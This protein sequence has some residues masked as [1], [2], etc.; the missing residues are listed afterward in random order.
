MNHYYDT[1]VL[2]KLYTEEPESDRVREWVTPIAERLPFHAFHLS[3]TISALQ[4]KAY[5]GE[6]GIDQS[7]RAIADIEEDRADGLLQNVRPD[8]DMV[9]EKCSQ[10]A[11]SHAAATGCR[12]LDTLHVACARTLGFRRFVSTDERQRKLAQRAGLE[13][14][15][16][17]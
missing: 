9:W 8:W 16:P 4:L 13:V 3:E 11:Q 6:C 5:R 10:L 15:R 1:G 17:C 7:N 2:L 14:F 12:T